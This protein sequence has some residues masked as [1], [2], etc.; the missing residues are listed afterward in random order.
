MGFDSRMRDITI[1]ATT[2]VTI[3]SLYVAWTIYRGN[4]P[5][6]AVAVTE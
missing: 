3:I 2:V 4:K 5:G 6:G 1:G